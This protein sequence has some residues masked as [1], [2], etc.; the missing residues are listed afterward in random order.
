MQGL[1]SGNRKCFI[2]NRHGCA[3]H[4]VGTRQVFASQMD[5]WMGE[6][7]GGEGEKD[8][9]LKGRGQTVPSTYP[10]CKPATC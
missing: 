3:W 6:A 9:R 5:G 7:G 1:V 2:N 8:G 4:M 10:W